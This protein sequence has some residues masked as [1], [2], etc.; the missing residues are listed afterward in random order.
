MLVGLAAGSVL[1]WMVGRP[2]AAPPPPTQMLVVDRS[3]APGTFPTI[4]AALR[5]A[6]PDAHIVVRADTWA[7]ALHVPADGSG[8]VRIEGQAPGG[9]PVRWRVPQDHPAGQP[10][11]RVTGR[12]GLHL[13]G[14]VLDG[15]NRLHNLV[16]VAG[17]C[18]A[19]SLEDL[20]LTG[21]RQNAAAFRAC[22]GTA[23][24]PVTLR[25]VRIASG[26]QEASALSFEARADELNQHLHVSDCRLE[27]P[28]SA[29]VVLDGP[30]EGIVFTHNRIWQ[31]ADA[32]LYRKA[33]PAHPLG[34]TL[35]GNTV[36]AAEKAGLHFETLPP[37]GRSRVVLTGNLFARTATLACVDDFAAG[38]PQTPAQWLDM[39]EIFP[40]PSG[41]V[42]DEEGRE[43]F[44]PLKAPPHP[45]ELPT[46]PDDARFLRYP[47]TSPL[48]AAGSP[49]VPPSE[50]RP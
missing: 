34:L 6:P 42:C 48:K 16:L 13:R 19:L 38:T 8:T 35:A 15:D 9:S 17:P 41:N 25:R 14:M 7:E 11:L 12:A 28:F 22:S 10:L 43:G 44:P 20:H 46:D 30:A 33:A 39:A 29:A 36:C 50:G 1:R 23:E 31:A 24:R 47:A 26:R 18:P 45:F 40:R 2:V 37:V 21:F 5:Q 4:A 3:G 27:G 32:F 49:G